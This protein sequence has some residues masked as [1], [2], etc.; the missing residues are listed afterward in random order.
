MVPRWFLRVCFGLLAC[1]LASE[2]CGL[3]SH[4]LY[5]AAAWTAML[6]LA[7]ALPWYR[8]ER[9]A[10]LGLLAGLILTA[11]GIAATLAASLP[12]LLGL[13]ICLAGLAVMQQ[14]LR[15]PAPDLQVLSAAAL[16]YVLL[17]LIHSVSPTVWW[18]AQQAALAGSR[19][20][21][22]WLDRDLALSS[23]YFGLPTT[24]LVLL[25]VVLAW[26][27]NARRGLAGVAGSIA[28][29][30][31]L[32]V[33]YLVL[34]ALVPNAETLLRMLGQNPKP[35]TPA[36]LA[37]L[38]ESTIPWNWPA[39]WVLLSLIPAWLAAGVYLSRAPA[40]AQRPGRVWAWLLAAACVLAAAGVLTAE[41]PIPPPTGKQI[42]FYRKGFL[43]WLRPKHGQYGSRS[44]GMFGNLPLFAE[45]L[46]C[47]AKFIDRIDEA[48]LAEASV[49]VI[50]NPR[51]SDRQI[52]E[53]P[54]EAIDVIWDFVGRGG[55]LL[56]LGDHTALHIDKAGRKRCYLNEL[57]SP[58][59]IR[60]NFDSAY[61]KVG[62]WLHGYTYPRH[63]VVLG[64]GDRFNEP[65]SV[66]GASLRIDPPARPL[67]I[68]RIGW[69]DHGN[70][71]AADRG[72][73][74]NVKY[75][76]EEQ[77]GDV[78]LA[79]AQRFGKGRVI[80]FGD[81]SGFVNAILT[82]TYPFVG[83]VL[84]W[85]CS[86]QNPLPGDQRAL[87]A[88][89]LLAA[90]ALILLLRV[91]PPAWTG[92]VLILVGAAWWG[93]DRW[94]IARQ[95]V[96]PDTKALL[97][98]RPEE[99][100]LRGV[101]YVDYAH[102]GRFSREGWRDNGIAGLTLNFMRNGYLTFAA[103]DLLPDRLGRAALL[104]SVA[105]LKR[106]EA[107]EVA[108]VMDFVRNGGIFVLM[109]GWDEAGPSKPLL[110]ALDF[111]IEHVP[112]GHFK[113]RT[114]PDSEILARFHE[115]WP[116]RA[117]APGAESLV[118]Y[119]HYPLIQRRNIGKGSAVVIGDSSF[120]W[121]INLESEKAA[122]MESI[123]FWQWLLGYLRQTQPEANP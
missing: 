60:F 114:Q 79:A 88:G 2:Q 61:F 110:K 108:A 47:R 22:A 12:M 100:D 35:E 109:V 97:A 32:Q 105:P 103:H 75:D 1:A 17:G 99:K 122:Q 43:N 20:L 57:L 70:E 16:A 93:I 52:A 73:M 33:A 117:T 59:K 36:G 123:K 76:P 96:L 83:R 74:G 86:H 119:G 19:N 87:L 30:A 26:L 49:L 14:A 13:G 21:G 90:A 106:Y 10:A 116:V 27:R 34:V 8:R 45:S 77:L 91:P 25:F 107:D 4:G 15:Q 67:L 44:A 23:T 82:G 9:G 66:I 111:E 112:L 64:L 55:T 24:V 80:V 102:R 11:L 37:R 121:G 38:A 94:T 58:T 81:T 113:I 71:L 3:A 53:P 7:A 84:S 40:P 69:S 42:A 118:Q 62:G 68:G 72:F 95:R 120:A 29:L 78:V 6:G 46:G 85:A 50:I 92:L 39:V 104:A 18:W 98:A 89:V 51:I 101:A 28:L 115:A 54:E 56:L 41:R 31:A 63:P 48:S 65:G 5:R